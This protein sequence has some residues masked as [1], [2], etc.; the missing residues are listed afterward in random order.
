MIDDVV[1][2]SNGVSNNA[3]CGAC[4]MAVVWMHNQLAQNQTRI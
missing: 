4:E 1:E 2:E 3:M